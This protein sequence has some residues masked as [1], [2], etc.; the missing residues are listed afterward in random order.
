MR[1]LTCA[2]TA[3]L[4][5]GCG[6]AQ[7]DAE[8]LEK[9][10]RPEFERQLDSQVEELNSDASV[11]VESFSCIK[12]S[13]TEAKCLAGLAGYEPAFGGDDASTSITVDIDPDSG[14]YIW[15]QD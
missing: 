13:A 15:K 2:M 3:G 10:I 5:A 8:E 7:V 1:L 11:A 4:L 9:S 6:G 12:K 14:Q